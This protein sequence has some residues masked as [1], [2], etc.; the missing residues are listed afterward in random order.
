VLN[1]GPGRA[2]LAHMFQ[3]PKVP[4]DNGDRYTFEFTL[5]HA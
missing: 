5:R 1:D 2:R 4:A 3:H